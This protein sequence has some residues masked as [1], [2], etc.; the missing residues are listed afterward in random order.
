MALAKKINVGQT[1]YRWVVQPDDEPGMA[2]VVECSDNPGQRMITWME[3]GN[4]ISPW[5]VRYAILHALE[6]GWHPKQRGT[7]V[8]FRFEG[9]VQKQAGWFG[10]PCN[11]E[12]EWMRIF[13]ESQ[14]S[15]NLSAPCPI[16][17]RVAL[18]RWYQ[19]GKPIDLV[20]AGKK[21]VAEGG[22]WEWCSS[23]HCCEHSSCL[24][25]E[26]WSCSLEVDTA[27]LTASPTV[28]E[29][30]MERQGLHHNEN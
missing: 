18:H 12:A 29:E 15:L 1:E 21:F 5:L 8:V 11:H 17:G 28:I 14:E 19:V 2:L 9:I 7:V 22:L 4:I 10:V 16:C 25:P 6:N 27:N 20:I 24:V 3:Y 13:Q 23:C 30:A 26:W